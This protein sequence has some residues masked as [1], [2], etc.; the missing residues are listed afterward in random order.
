MRPLSDYSKLTNMNII[1]ISVC[2][3]LLLFVGLAEQFTEYYLILGETGVGKSSYVNWLAGT[4]LAKEGFFE[5]VTDKPTTYNVKRNGIDYHLI[6]VPGFLDT[7]SLTDAEIM[8]LVKAEV[9]S[10]DVEKISGVIMM[11]N[12]ND[13]RMRIE[14]IM[15]SVIELLGTHIHASLVV[16]INQ[17]ESILVDR[18]EEIVTKIKAKVQQSG[19]DATKVVVID[20]KADI[21]KY[22]PTLNQVLQRAV[23]YNVEGM[24][25]LQQR[26]A[27]ILAAELAKEENYKS[28]IEKK[29]EVYSEIESRPVTIDVHYSYECN[30]H[31][32]CKKILG[33]KINCST[34]CGTCHGTRKENRIENHTVTK[35]RYIDVPRR[36]INNDEDFYRRK[37]RSMAVEEIKNF[38]FSNANKRTE[39]NNSNEEKN[40]S[41]T[42]ASNRFA[43]TSAPANTQSQS[44]DEL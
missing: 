30:C 34:N 2:F 18:R 27:Q 29:P 37:A 22:F 16:V 11:V 43:G 17:Y 42:D 39:A 21:T 36:E 44:H 32:S 10:L 33:I 9:L 38:V 28:W 15:Q 13:N 5:S 31:Q 7:G 8:Q 41:T 14:K 6:D 20:T 23:P 35:V 19:A 12:G 26:V 24:N 3:L 1:Y 40:Q 25:Q 4:T